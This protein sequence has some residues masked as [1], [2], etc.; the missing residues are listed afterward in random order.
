MLGLRLDETLLRLCKLAVLATDGFY[1]RRFLK[2]GVAPAIEHASLLRR[3]AFDFVADVGA[4]RGQFSLVCR[5]VN[6]GAKIVGFEP[7][8]EPA[9]IYRALFADD[10]GIRLCEAAL[11]TTSGKTVMHVSARD[12]SSSLLPIAQAQ[13]DNYP[14]SG[15]VGT[16]EVAVT[17][18]PE[19]VSLQ[20]LGARNLLK[21][22]V[23]GFELEVLKSAGPLLPQFAWVYVECS[24]I[25]LY[26]GQ[27]LAD[28]VTAFLLARGFALSGRYNVS[29]IAGTDKP[30]QA[31]LLFVRS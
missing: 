9:R 2:H 17:T 18:L 12:D 13:T 6:T 3:L 26:E 27:P 24:Y 11:G 23:Q 10:P 30:L 31:D 25:P 20:E 14:G 8:A 21:I 28:D 7:L 29:F 19:A 4:N 16:R 22:D 5:R 1:R 15:E